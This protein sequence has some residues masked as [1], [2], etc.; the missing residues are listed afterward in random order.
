MKRPTRAAATSVRSSV[1]GRSDSQPAT[2]AGSLSPPQPASGEGA[3]SATRATTPDALCQGFRGALPGL[4]AAGPTMPACFRASSSSAA[5]SPPSARPRRCAPATTAARS[6]SC[7]GSRS[8]PTTARRCPRSCAPSRSGPPTGTPS[9]TSSCCSAGAPRGS[10]SAARRVTLEEGAEL[11][12]DELIIAT[13]A[14]PRRLPMLRRA[15]ERV[16][17]AHARGRRTA[18]APRSRRAPGSRSSAPASSAR[19][20]PPPRAAS[21]S[22]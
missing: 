4:C 8:L 3:H 6:G 9:T 17:P 15:P 11:G 20:W 13:G 7:A 21:A 18:C 19:R 10:T 22:R 12:Y 14:H 1:A 5:G 16:R 2:A